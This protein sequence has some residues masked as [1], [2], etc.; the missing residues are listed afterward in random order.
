MAET[1][2]TFTDEDLEI[3][4]N[5]GLTSVLEGLGGGGGDWVQ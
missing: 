1:A 2:I 5:I 3:P 4:L